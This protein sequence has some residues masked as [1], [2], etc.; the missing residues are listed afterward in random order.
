MATPTTPEELIARARSIAPLF[1]EQALPSERLR[2]PS[3]E[4]IEAVEEAE[5]F[6]L[7]VPRRYGGLELDMD[8]FVEVVLALSEGDASLAW[9]TAFLIEH[10][11]MFSL[12]P[13]SFQ[14]Q[15]FADRSY[16]LAPGMIAPTGLARPAAGGVVL[17]GRWQF[18]TGVW[19]SSWIIAGAI[20]LN[21]D[22]QPDPRFFAIPREEV[23]VEDTW[24]V[25]GMCGTGSHDVVIDECFVPDDRS[26]SILDMNR[27]CT[28]G[29]EIH[30]G[31]LYRT[32]M[33]PLLTA[34]A[35][36]PSLGQA[37]ALVREYA[38][39]LPGRQRMGHP[40]TQA[41]STT[42]QIRLARLSIA[43]DQTELLLRDTV[44]DLCARRERCEAADRARMQAR[45]A[46]VVD[47]SKQIISQVCAASG[48]NAHQLSDPF[49]RA[50]R[51]VEVMGTHVAFDLDAS[52]ENTG[53]TML[54][55]EVSAML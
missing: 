15:L 29:A 42:A 28:P 50:R 49:Q 37:R 40:T 16:V 22:E 32:P 54:G 38:R 48:A 20:L 34:T 12:F 5:I 9:V 26:V 14:K 17:S 53:K 47:Q 46:T 18:A 27:G 44:R 55:L 3:D 10:N 2:R 33:V 1:A 6:K 7:M 45:F 21:D 4:A 24:H 23:T 39:R 13:E 8:T 30:D 52:L 11:W 35:A 41:E 19:H 31:P 36:M 51:D 25:D 43:V